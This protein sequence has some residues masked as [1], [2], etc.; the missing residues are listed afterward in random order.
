MGGFM[1]A[2]GRAQVPVP[3]A[4][5]IASAM[6]AVPIVGAL[7]AAGIM[8]AMG[9]YGS[10]MGRERAYQQALP[11]IYDAGRAY[12][13]KM[14]TEAI[15]RKVPVTD[16]KMDERARAQAAIQEQ[17]AARKEGGGFLRRMAEVGGEILGDI[18]AAEI[19][20]HLIVPRFSENKTAP[21]LKY[22]PRGRE[23]AAAG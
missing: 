3:S 22:A 10:Y 1:G 5:G 21:V 19:A 11:H 12:R 6:M 4:G 23:L 18:A 16:T 2:A 9:A 14:V 13:E 17:T 8:T 20:D 15:T 7:G